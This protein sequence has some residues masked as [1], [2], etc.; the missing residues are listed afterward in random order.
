MISTICGIDVLLYL[1]DALDD[2]VKP[3]GNAAK[4]TGDLMT[5]RLEIAL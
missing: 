2:D 5:R 1:G 4:G 3:L